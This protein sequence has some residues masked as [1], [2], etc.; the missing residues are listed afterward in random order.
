MPKTIPLHRIQ[1]INYL[2]SMRHFLSCGQPEGFQPHDEG[3]DGP[4]LLSKLNQALSLLEQAEAPILGP[5]PRELVWRKNKSRLYRYTSGAGDQSI[6][7]FVMYGLINKP[8]ILD[9]S[10]QMSF[11]AYLVNQ[12]FTV[13][14]LDWGSFGPEDASLGIS[15]LLIN[16]V[17]RAIKAM[18]TAEGHSTYHL[19]GYC[20]G[21]TLASI[22]AAYASSQLERALEP[23]SL[24]LLASPIDFSQTGLIGS[25]LSSERL[26]VDSWANQMGNI[27]GEWITWGN[28]LVRPY[29]NFFLPLK[30]LIL[31][32]DDSPYVRR[33]LAVDSW[34]H[35]AV[36]FPK[37]AF[38]EWIHCFY[39]ENQLVRN[40]YSLNQQP[41]HLN[42]ITCPLLT[43]VAEKDQL[44]T[45]FQIDPILTAVSSQ[46][47]KRLGAQ[48]GHVSLVISSYAQEQ[49]WPQLVYWLQ[50]QS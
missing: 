30:Q 18:Q 14:L 33:W 13:Y 15:S 50:E 48:T 9:L 20:M 1:Q 34:I 22:W 16:Y 5:T 21:G 40:L 41:I 44:V 25:W 3:T 29:E 6:P 24:V 32:S 43:V 26:H 39:Q 17:P 2:R 11:I 49:V 38:I 12:G 35:D 7:L 10:E 47:V 46:V 31:H 42:Q 8:T 37:T 27:P 4:S 19:L 23:S 45:P 36:F 28:M